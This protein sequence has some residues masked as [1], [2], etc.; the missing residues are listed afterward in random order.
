MAVPNEK[1]WYLDLS[2]TCD[3]VLLLLAREASSQSA[4]DELTCRHWNQFKAHLPR[5]GIRLALT[6][7]DLEDA[8]QQAFFWIQEAIGAFDPA[9][10]FLQR[11]SSFRTFLSRVLRRRLLNFCRSLRRRTTR[12][13]LVAELSDWPGTLLANGGLDFN[14]DG[15]ELHLLLDTLAGQLDPAGRVLWNHLR[16][17][18]RLRDLPQLLG[19][20][21]RTVK[22]RW[23]KLR[24]HLTRAVRQ[25]HGCEVK[26]DQSHI[27]HPSSVIRASSDCADGTGRHQS[28]S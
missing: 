25:P 17:G 26:T 16:Q 28:L 10:L 1:G 3:E 6:S 23:R 27:A 5:Y 4:R 9:Q 24:E 18:K 20:T 8:Q 14:G 7:W 12:F 22:R 2:H 21:Y 15:K 13:R 19:V 11:G